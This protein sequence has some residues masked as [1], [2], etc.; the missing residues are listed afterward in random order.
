IKI[1]RV[2]NKQITVEAYKIEQSKFEKGNGKRLDMQITV[3]GTKR[4]LF[5]G[6][7]NLM[8]MIQQVP[9]DKFPFTTTIVRENERLI[10]T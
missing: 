4:L 2:L 5:T 7:I 6:S 3:D 1:D 9:S 10:F 8:D